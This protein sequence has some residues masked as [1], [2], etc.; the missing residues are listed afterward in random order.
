MNPGVT[1]GSGP[2][3]GPGPKSGPGAGSGAI[4]GPNATS[5]G[6][7]LGPTADQQRPVSHSQKGMALHISS[8]MF[9]LSHLAS[10]PLV[11]G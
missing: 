10:H 3:S 8:L 6:H 5:S 4:A 1:V 7:G 9:T 2:T 11:P